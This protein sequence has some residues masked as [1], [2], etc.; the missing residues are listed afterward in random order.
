[1]SVNERYGTFKNLPCYTKKILCQEKKISL[2]QEHFYS[3]KMR[4][5]QRLFQLRIDL[6]KRVDNYGKYGDRLGL[7]YIT[8]EIV[9]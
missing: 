3:A 6:S 2:R 9:Q 5:L 7:T 1:M 4:S 8:Y